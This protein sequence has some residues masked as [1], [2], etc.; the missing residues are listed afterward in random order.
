MPC[1]ICLGLLLVLAM[2]ALALIMALPHMF[3]LLE[4]LGR[5]IAKLTAPPTRV[6]VFGAIVLGLVAAAAYFVLKAE[7]GAFDRIFTALS[8]VHDA[9]HVVP[10]ATQEQSPS[11]HSSEPHAQAP[12]AS[13]IVP[14]GSKAAEVHRPSSA[15]QVPEHKIDT[16]ECLPR[17]GA[18]VPPGVKNHQ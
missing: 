12:A 16:A 15:V 8:R 1:L 2:L 3:R 7:H 11:K 5:D 14:R 4:S 6:L 10:P 17:E 13:E 18:R 9:L